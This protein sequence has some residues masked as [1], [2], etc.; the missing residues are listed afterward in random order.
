MVLPKRQE[1]FR[2]NLA[3]SDNDIFHQLRKTLG[4]ALQLGKAIESFQR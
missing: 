4:A 1:N 2:K 3:G